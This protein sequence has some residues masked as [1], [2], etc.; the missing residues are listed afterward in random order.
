MIA[1][2]GGRAD[3][4]GL[5]ARRCSPTRTPIASSALTFLDIDW[6]LVE[7]ELERMRELD[8]LRARTPRTSCATW[9][10]SPTGRSEPDARE[11]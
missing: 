5:A 10:P 3:H 7:R 9:A 8:A 2:L 1:G 6:E 11:R 4:A